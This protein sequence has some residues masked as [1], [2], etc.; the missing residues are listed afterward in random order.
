MCCCCPATNL[1][2]MGYILQVLRSSARVYTVHRPLHEPMQQRSPREY[3]AVATA[4]A[5]TSRDKRAT[6][7][8][9]LRRPSALCLTKHNSGTACVSGHNP[10]VAF[11]AA[12][13]GRG[14]ATNRLWAN[15]Y[16]TFRNERRLNY[17]GVL[18]RRWR[19]SCRT[20]YLLSAISQFLSLLHQYL[21]PQG[22]WTCHSRFGKGDSGAQS[23]R[24]RAEES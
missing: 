9:S 6:R 7:S 22:R 15:A 16:F 11:G 8:S 17:V 1:S 5:C 14:A 18:Q 4:G 13:A 12:R 20:A 21:C 24:T 3:T 2:A 23:T 19:K 10:K